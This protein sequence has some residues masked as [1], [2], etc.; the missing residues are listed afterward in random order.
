MAIRWQAEQLKEGSLCNQQETRD[1]Y[2]IIDETIATVHHAGNLKRWHEAT[3]TVALSGIRNTLS[4]CDT[5]L[6]S[7]IHIKNKEQSTK[8][9]QATLHGFDWPDYISN[10]SPLWWIM[11]NIYFCHAVQKLKLV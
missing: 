9:K 11:L 1:Q 6:P 2:K 7:S 4:Q 3:Q 5:R 10:L 8:V